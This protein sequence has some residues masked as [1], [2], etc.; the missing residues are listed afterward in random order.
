MIP[1]A[2]G[3]V[4]PHGRSGPIAVRRANSSDMAAAAALRPSGFL[5]RAPAGYRSISSTRTIR[6]QG[7]GLVASGAT[8]DRS[9]PPDVL[10]ARRAARRWHRRPVSPTTTGGLITDG[11]RAIDV[12]AGLDLVDATR[13]RDRGRSQGG[14]LA[15]AV[16]ALSPSDACSDRRRPVP[17]SPSAGA[18][19]RR[20]V[21]IRRDSPSPATSARHDR[22][23]SAYTRLLRRPQFRGPGMAP[24]CSPWVSLTRH[25]RR[26]TSLRCLPA[27]RGPKRIVVMAF[28]GHDAADEDSTT[29]GWTFSRSTWRAVR[30]T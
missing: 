6:G 17:V 29:N 14:Y 18:R 25:V 24:R 2:P 5:C 21:A 7:W 26:P 12:L 3:L 27:P 11:V 28:G 9:R 30:P 16:A 10:P 22:R 23:R 20:A 19:D 1:F 15:L 13:M 8:S 4:A